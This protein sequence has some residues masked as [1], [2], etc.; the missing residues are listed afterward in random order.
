[1]LANWEF[2]CSAVE[3]GY[4]SLLC[5][6]DYQLPDFFQ[7]AAREMNRHPEIG[8]CFGVTNVVDEDGRHLSIAPNEMAT[9]YYLAGEG[10]VAMMTL[11][12]PSTP[13]IH[14]RAACLKAGEGIRWAL[15][16]LMMLGL[17]VWLVVFGLAEM[18]MVHMVERPLVKSRQLLGAIRQCFSDK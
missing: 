8:L 15:S 7:A 9:V 10:A 2:A 14:F 3:A 4:F 18:I 6:D 13:A 5:E 16:L 11:Q 1:M 17:T 12:H